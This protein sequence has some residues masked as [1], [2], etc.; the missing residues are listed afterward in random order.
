ML[1][2]NPVEVRRFEHPGQGRKRAKPTPKGRQ[3]EPE[4][5]HEIAALLGDRPR[6]RDLLIE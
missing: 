4:A 5:H 6:H 1:N 3:I 2:E